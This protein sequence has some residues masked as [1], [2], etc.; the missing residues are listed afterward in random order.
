[1][2]RHGAHRTYVVQYELDPD[3][4]EPLRPPRRLSVAS[5]NTHDMPQFAAFWEGSDID[6]RLDLGLLSEKQARAESAG[7]KQARAAVIARLRATGAL[8]SSRPGAVEVL[9]ALLS[10]LGRSQAGVVLANLEDL[11]GETAPQN[12]PG[13][14]TER[15]NWRRRARYSL[16]DAKALPVVTDTLG[17]LASARA[18]RGRGWGAARNG[19][20][21]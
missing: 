19:R 20:H 10:A 16:E 4:A 1:M 11:W 12:T 14:S 9:K 2:S 18:E 15:V 7:R 8:K 13:T 6:D 5:L 21:R 3:A 17:A